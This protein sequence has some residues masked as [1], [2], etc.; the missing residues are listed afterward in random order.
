MATLHQYLKEELGSFWGEDSGRDSC[1]QETTAV[2][3]W[4]AKITQLTAPERPNLF[5]DVTNLGARGRK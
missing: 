2:R 3:P 5:P 4:K 1:T